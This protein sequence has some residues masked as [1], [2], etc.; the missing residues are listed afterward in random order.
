[1]IRDDKK[2]VVP[3]GMLPVFR[4]LELQEQGWLGAATD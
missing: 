1:A 4:R 2:G 3:A